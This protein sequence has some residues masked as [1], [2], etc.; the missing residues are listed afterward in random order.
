M[1]ISWQRGQ[2]HGFSI[3]LNPFATY[4]EEQHDEVRDLLTRILAPQLGRSP[5]SML[6]ERLL[7]QLKGCPP[8]YLAQ[9]ILE[10]YGTSIHT[11]WS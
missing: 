2:I 3:R 10:G 7:Q 11:G 9:R 1:E 5:D 6:A 4:S 8:E